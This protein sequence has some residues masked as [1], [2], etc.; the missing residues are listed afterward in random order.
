MLR[1]IIFFIFIATAI[2]SMAYA[3]GSECNAPKEGSTLEESCFLHKELS[4]QDNELNSIYQHLLRQWA[5]DDFKNE[6]ISLVASQRAWLSYRDKTCALAQTVNGGM[7]SISFSRC[8]VQLT[9]ERAA[10]LKELL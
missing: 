4:H 7:L 8:L 6:R 3:L 10:F 5:S 1:S 2:P 9:S